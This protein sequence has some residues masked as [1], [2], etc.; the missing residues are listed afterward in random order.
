MSRVI[1]CLFLSLLGC[2]DGPQSRWSALIGAPMLGLQQPSP[3]WPQ[4]QRIGLVVH[5]DTTKIE[6]AP[7][8]SQPFLQTLGRRTEKILHERCRVSSVVPIDFPSSNQHAQI[9]QELMA[10][11]QENEI[12]HLLLVIF[13]G[14]EHSAPV[15]LGE[16]TMMTQMTG[17]VFENT[18][19][20]ELALLDL[21][22][23]SMAFTIPASATETLEWLDAPIGSGRPT[24]DESLK[25]LRAQAGQQALDRSLYGLGQWCDDIPKNDQT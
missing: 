15:T 2:G 11:G 13:S 23:Y 9:R 16:E 19:Q 21:A 22:E 24:L 4:P 14:Q 10:R 6:A 17:T 25:I 1:L 12:S 18:T 7:S 20:V 8:I 5:A 3:M